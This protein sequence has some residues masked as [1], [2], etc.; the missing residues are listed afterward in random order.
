M[1]KTFWIAGFVAMFF[2]MGA[3]MTAQAEQAS[4]PKEQAAS[5]LAVGPSN[6]MMNHNMVFLALQTKVQNVSQMTQMT[7]NI[8]KADSDAK[9]NVV[10]NMRN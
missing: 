5:S 3:K 6:I 10:R 9:L 1:I 7:S 2:I 4:R 8:A